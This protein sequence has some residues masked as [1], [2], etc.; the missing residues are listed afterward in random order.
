MDGADLERA[1]LQELRDAQ[2]LRAGVGE[3]ELAGD[4]ALEQVEV[5]RRG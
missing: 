2:A 4:A 5:L 3:V 1:V